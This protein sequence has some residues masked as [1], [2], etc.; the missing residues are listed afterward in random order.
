MAAGAAAGVLV[1]RQKL[2]NV[3]YK[4]KPAEDNHRVWELLKPGAKVC[5]GGGLV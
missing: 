5:S 4:G 2:L 1:K 3:R